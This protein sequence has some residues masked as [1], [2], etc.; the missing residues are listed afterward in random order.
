[1]SK[2]INIGNITVDITGSIILFDP[3]CIEIDLPNEKSITVYTDG[4]KAKLCPNWELRY[5]GVGEKE[6]E[7]KVDM[8]EY[9]N[10]AVY[11]VEAEFEIL[12]KFINKDLA[13]VSFDIRE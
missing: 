10:I 9:N 12:T 5:L 8:G 7:E 13:K 2:F 11:V 4:E 1:M 3:C 6:A